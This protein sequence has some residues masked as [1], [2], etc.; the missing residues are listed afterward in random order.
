MASGL[1]KLAVVRPPPRRRRSRGSITFFVSDEDFAHVPEGF[2]FELHAAPV[3]ALK[4]L[5]VSPDLLKADKAIPSLKSAL[6]AERKKSASDGEFL[7]HLHGLLQE[8]IPNFSASST[9]EE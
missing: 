9:Y 4:F 8:I 5:E 3:P 6:L 1:P 7:E 2:Q